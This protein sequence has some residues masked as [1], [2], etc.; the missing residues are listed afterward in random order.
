VLTC[1]NKTL[2]FNVE[3]VAQQRESEREIVVVVVCLT[4][5]DLSMFVRMTKVSC[6]HTCAVRELLC[7]NNE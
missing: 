2:K 7:D 6:L 4:T 1:V 5:R 3:S